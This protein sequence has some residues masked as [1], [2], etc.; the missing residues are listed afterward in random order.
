MRVLLRNNRLTELGQINERLAAVISE[1]RGETSARVVSARPL[2]DG[3]KSEIQTGLEKLT[4]KKVSIKY[5][6]DGKY[7]RRVITIIGLTVYDGSVK[8]QLENLKKEM[9]GN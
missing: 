2:G 5:E 9:I 8:T 4:G 7:Y 6:T 3:E 1:R